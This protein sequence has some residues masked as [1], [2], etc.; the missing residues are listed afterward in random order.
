MHLILDI[1][2]LTI[3]TSG[4]AQT[5]F[6]IYKNLPTGIVP[7]DLPCRDK[8]INNHKANKS[9][10]DVH[11]RFNIADEK[12]GFLP[13]TGA[14]EGHWEMSYWNLPD[15][16]KL[17]A[18]YQEGCGPLCALE[19]FKFFYYENGKIQSA[20]IQSVIPGYKTIYEDFFIQDPKASKLKLEDQDI[21]TTLLFQLP[22]KGKTITAIFDIEGSTE[23]CFN[24]L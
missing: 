10:Q 17:V 5:L 1:S 12:N 3:S 14:F 11:Y 9:T 24:V 2:L 6:D 19:I 21:I 23:V 16:K 20:D 13:V 18:V 8:M 7:C 4:I 22:R 15:S